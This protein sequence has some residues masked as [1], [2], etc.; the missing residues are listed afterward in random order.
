MYTITVKIAANGTIYHDTDTSVTGHM[1]YSISNGNSTESYGFAPAK[2]GM[3]IW[4]GTIKTTDDDYYKTT[5]YTGMIVIEQWQYEQLEAFGNLNNLNNNPFDFSSFYIGT[6][7]SCI[8]Y[9]WKALN[10]IGLNPSDFEGQTWPTLNADD[11]D[12]TLYKYLMGDTSGWNESL[13]DAGGYDAIYGSSGSDV[14]TSK[15]NI[16]AIYGG[17]G[18]DT[19]F[20]SL[21]NEYLNGGEGDDTI[22]G[23]LGQDT[24]VGD[25]G[26]DTLLGGIGNDILY[27]DRDNDKLFGGYDNDT[28]FGGSGEDVLLG[29]SG[30]DTLLGD[31]DSDVLYGGEGQDTLIGGDDNA[32]DVLFGGSGA[33]VLLGGAGAD[34]LAGGDAQNLYAD[35]ELDYL[36]G[37]V[38]HDIYYVSHQDIINDADSTGFIMFNNKTIN[39]KKTKVDEYTYEDA[40]FTYTLDGNNLIVV[41]KNLGEYITIENFQNSAMGIKL[42]IDANDEDPTKKDIEIYV[43]DATVTESGTLEFTIGID[44]TLDKDLVVNVS[45]YF[46]GSAN[47]NDLS[48][49]ISGTVTIKA[50][51]TFGTFEIATF[52]DTILEPIENFIFAVTGLAEAYGDKISINNTSTC[53]NV[54][55]ANNYLHVDMKEVA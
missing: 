39:G 25:I 5:Y 49:P 6:S 2:D 28:L 40:N 4:E 15:L 37:G 26:Q 31:N 14:L 21:E 23:G 47:S 16:D 3:P 32:S 53:Q 46:N 45:S 43:G 44:N 12:A 24:L 20:G 35:K 51:T 50:G 13:P 48:S 42:D 55:L 29:E 38:G 19:I 34:T 30:H 18:S 54:L 33:D 41:D 17:N 52:D 10:I 1:W 9:T 27:G 22:H 8:D 11:A 7:N 36:A